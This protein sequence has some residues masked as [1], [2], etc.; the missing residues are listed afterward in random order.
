VRLSAVKSVITPS[1][2]DFCSHQ[3]A[4]QVT[5]GCGLAAS[6]AWP[7]LQR[8]LV[9]L[10]I[11]SG[12]SKS[13][14]RDFDRVLSGLIQRPS[15]QVLIQTGGAPDNIRGKKRPSV[16][17]SKDDAARRS[18]IPPVKTMKILRQSCR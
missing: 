17:L 11:Q 15:L 2:I 13:K 5:V 8:R 12:A 10:A 14:R 16:I 4:I 9:L 18:G 6:G 1:Q 7:D 3:E